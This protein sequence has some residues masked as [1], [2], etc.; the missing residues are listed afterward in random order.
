MGEASI[1]A[2]LVFTYNNRHFL[3]TFRFGAAAYQVRKFQISNRIR[4]WGNASCMK[5]LQVQSECEWTFQASG[6]NVKKHRRWTFITFTIRSGM[7]EKWNR[8]ANYT[9]STLNWT[10]L[11]FSLNRKELIELIGKFFFTAF[12]QMFPKVSRL[13][14][15]IDLNFWAIITQLLSRIA[16]I[17]AFLGL[18]W[19]SFQLKSRPENYNTFLLRVKLL[20]N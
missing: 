19:K 4:A 17:W 9:S 6:Q 15:L 16:R 13:V 2:L 12:F 5:C 3:I 1:E 11:E 10:S 7:Q 14:G 8:L 20:L 18:F